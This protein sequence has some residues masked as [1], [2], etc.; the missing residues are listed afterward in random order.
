MD[1]LKPRFQGLLRPLMRR[2]AARRITPDKLTLL[3]LG[4]SIAVGVSLTLARYMSLL[5]LLLPLWLLIRMALNA[6][7]AMMAREMGLTS[8]VSG[9]VHELGDVL[10]D[11]SLYV[12]L[13]WFTDGARTAVLAFVAGVVM[14]EFCGLLG[15]LVGSRR[16]R[17]GPMGKSYR[18]LAV[19]CIA[20]ATALLP[21]VYL[22]WGPIFWGL[23]A[24]EAWT[25]W[26]RC[27]A[28]VT[29]AAKAP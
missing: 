1:D 25:C 6:L 17:Q 14:T 20:V 3:S 16:Q 18:A 7:D 21:L 2:L 5:L 8:A 19:S 10:S 15:V 22:L 4:G 28:A 13:A 24:L 23:T 11:L 9:A 27:A 26:N 12:P 29:E